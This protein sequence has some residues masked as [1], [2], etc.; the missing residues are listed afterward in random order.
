M[1]NLRR[2]AAFAPWNDAPCLL[3][4]GAYLFNRF[5]MAPHYGASWPILRDHFNDS[6]L[7]PAALP[8]LYW[9]RFRLKLRH[10]D[11]PLSWRDVLLWCAL[12]SLF[13]EWIGPR[14]LHHS[15]GD[16]GDVAAYFVGGVLAAAWWNRPSQKPRE[17][18]RAAPTPV[19]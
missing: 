7:I 11:A 15:V 4:W 18:G 2:C 9:V 14:Y 17:G 19:S 3:A 12:W 16:W 1:S 13:F 5:W 6:L 8:L 10:T